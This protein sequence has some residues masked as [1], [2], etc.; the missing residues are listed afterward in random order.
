MSREL[1]KEVLFSHRLRPRIPENFVDLEAKLQ[2]TAPGYAPRSAPD[3]LDWIKE[4]VL[5]PV[6]EWQDLLKAID[7]DRDIPAGGMALIKRKIISFPMP[8]ATIPL[9]C[10]LEN[11]ERVVRGFNLRPKKLKFGRSFHGPINER[12]DLWAAVVV[13]KAFMPRK[14]EEENSPPDILLQWL[15]FYG[16][17]GRSSLKEIFGLDESYLDEIISGLA[18]SQEVVF[19]R[20]TEKAGE[21][22]ICD[23]ENLEILLRM[24]RK[25]REPVFKTLGLDHLPLFLAA[26]QG[27]TQKGDSP[28]DLQRVLDQLFGFPAEAEAW[29]K[30]ILPARLSPYYGSWL[31]HLGRDSDLLWFGCG[32]EK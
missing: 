30:H 18:E 20:L 10:A 19:D 8:K 6:T 26:F 15:S 11:L 14:D 2:R 9:V 16:P 29:E 21:M 7:Q 1:L 25:S 13:N 17:V 4:R 27:L 12:T 24:A 5:I 3:L 28:E 22:E 32:K 31:D 23:R